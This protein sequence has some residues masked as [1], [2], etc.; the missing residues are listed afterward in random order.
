MQTQTDIQ[1][2]RALLNEHVRRYAHE[3][4][5]PYNYAWARLYKKYEELYRIDLTLPARK[6]KQS[7]LD[8]AEK[9]GRIKGL[10]ALAEQQLKIN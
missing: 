7:P 3:S 6:N 10:L 5:I 2:K 8:Y 4:G 9:T 1:S